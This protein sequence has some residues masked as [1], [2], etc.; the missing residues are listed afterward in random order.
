MIGSDGAR[1]NLRWVGSFIVVL[2]VHALVIGGA[3]YWQRQPLQPV[4]AAQ[5]QAV[6]VE[7]APLATAPEAAPSDVAPGPVQQ[8]TA[9]AQAVQK[10]Q[11][12]AEPLPAQPPMPPL[13]T[14]AAAVATPQEHALSQTTASAA[15]QASAPPQVDAARSSRYAAPQA[16]A[17]S[18]SPAFADWQAQLL[19]HLERFKR[20]P[21]AAQR[22][23]YEGV[24]Q[25][26]YRVD[27]LGNVLMAQLERSSGHAPLDEE[28]LAAVQRASPLPPPP[29]EVT[30]DPVD[31]TTPVQFF[32][33]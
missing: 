6:M 2:A 33:R 22:R 12:Q 16:S 9:A 29:A 28:A 11:P 13:P 26:H 27:R 17:G 5:P 30:G 21:R 7:L 24:V 8:E 23:R 4:A 20:Y 14:A 3:M 18:S 10:P 25:V 15:V 32:M 31:V 19:G 1:K